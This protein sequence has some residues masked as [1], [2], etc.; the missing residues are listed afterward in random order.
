MIHEQKATK[1]TKPISA[2]E[3]GELL[4]ERFEKLHAAYRTMF[5]TTNEHEGFPNV[6]RFVLIRVY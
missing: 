2:T 1:E 5:L 6:K 3:A 4:G